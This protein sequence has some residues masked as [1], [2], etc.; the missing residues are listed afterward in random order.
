[1]GGSPPCRRRRWLLTIAAFGIV[2][3][4]CGTANFQDDPLADAQLSSSTVQD[5]QATQG[6]VVIDIPKPTDADRGPPE[7]PTTITVQPS[8]EASSTTAATTAER[9]EPTLPAEPDD[10]GEPSAYS[11]VAQATVPAMVAR[12][13]PSDDSATVAHF[14]NPTGS[15]AP[16]VFQAVAGGTNTPD[17]IEVRLPIQPNGSTG[18]IRRQDVELSNNPYRLEVDRASYSLRVF[19]RND[20]WLESTVAIGTGATPTPVGDFY[21]LELLRPLTENGPY[22]PFAFGLS[23]FSEVLES[24]G[25]AD[26]AIIGIHGTNDPASIGTDVSH[27]CIRLENAVIEQLASTLPLGTPVRIT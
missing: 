10:R 3:S 27:G 13:S 25:G 18:W 2:S 11:I 8:S 19:Y 5:V 1:M 12:S 21:L 14:T 23:G 24:F 9:F 6:S 4:S 15:G 16:L 17:W 7:T 20:L 22:G 26:S